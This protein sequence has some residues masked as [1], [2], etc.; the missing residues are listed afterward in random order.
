M[1]SSSLEARERAA[2]ILVW[3]MVAL[4]PVILVPE[5]KY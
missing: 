4:F 3:P 1:S 2:H 5:Q